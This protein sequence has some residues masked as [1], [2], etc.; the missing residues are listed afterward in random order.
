MMSKFTLG[1]WKTYK[2]IYGSWRIDAADGSAWIAKTV[3][4]RSLETG[5]AEFDTEPDARL[6]AAAP[7]LL[8]ALQNLLKVNE[9]EGGTA[10]HACDIARDAIAKALGEYA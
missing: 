3:P 7:D 1:P 6:I 9:G 2:D 4:I 10:Y 5:M 8:F